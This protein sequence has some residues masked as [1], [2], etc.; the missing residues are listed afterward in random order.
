MAITNAV[1]GCRDLDTMEMALV[2]SVILHDS[3]INEDGSDFG[4]GIT[5]IRNCKGCL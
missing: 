5:H 4:E 3:H 1:Q 2:G